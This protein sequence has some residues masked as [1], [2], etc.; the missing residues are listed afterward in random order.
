[1]SWLAL[2]KAH[3]SEKGQNPTDKTDE[4]GVLSVS[5]VPSGRIYEFQ[6]GVSSV[7]S[8]GVTGIFENCIS[9][10]ELI[11]A[12]M[13]ACDHW[14]DSPQARDDMRRQCKEIPVHLRGELMEH[15]RTSY[16]EK[17]AKPEVTL[18][19]LDEPEPEPKPDWKVL[20]QAYLAHHFNCAFCVAAG[21]GYGKRC[22]V[23][24]TLWVNYQEASN[25]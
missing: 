6:R 4:M 21:K 14:G 16:P 3:F 17:T 7:S 5:S 1:M 20:D 18:T 15:F 22:P 11:E 25:E 8:V 23:G 12:A 10:E 19:S 9:A 24:L 13:R 2:A